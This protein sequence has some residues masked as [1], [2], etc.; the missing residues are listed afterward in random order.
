M[1]TLAVMREGQI[2]AAAEAIPVVIL[3]FARNRRV[4]KLS[5]LLD[6]R[7]VMVVKVPVGGFETIVEAL[8]LDLAE[9]PR[10]RIPSAAIMV[11]MILALPILGREKNGGAQ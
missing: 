4:T 7:R 1:K 3:E 10:R 2:V 8:P 5:L 9:L 6:I 11:R